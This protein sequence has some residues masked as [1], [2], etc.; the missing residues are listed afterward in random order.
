MQLLY[1]RQGYPSPGVGWEDYKS[2]MGPEFYDWFF[3]GK[4]TYLSTG[5]VMKDIWKDKP[6]FWDL[7][8]RTQNALFT[9]DVYFRQ[10]W[11]GEPPRTGSPDPKGNLR[12]L[13]STDDKEKIT[14][15]FLSPD[16]PDDNE[17]YVTKF[18][19]LKAN[20]PS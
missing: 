5:D 4:T 3:N 18:E 14:R 8:E 12:D 19:Q 13:G 17:Y 7:P 1:T 2:A 20:I 11:T 10:F 15:Y 16:L 9:P 6:E